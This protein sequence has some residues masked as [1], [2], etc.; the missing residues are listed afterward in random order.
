VGD[1]GPFIASVEAFAFSFRTL[2]PEGLRSA[3]GES[4][5]PSSRHPHRIRIAEEVAPAFV[6]EAVFPQAE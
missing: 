6:A 2:L 5:L 4:A 3:L 1:A